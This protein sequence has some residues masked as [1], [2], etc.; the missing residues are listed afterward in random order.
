[1]FSSSDLHTQGNWTYLKNVL[2]QII[3]YIKWMFSSSDFLNEY[4]FFLKKNRTP[5]KS[6]IYYFSYMPFLGLKRAPLHRE[7]RPITIYTEPAVLNDYSSNL[8]LCSMICLHIWMVM[9]EYFFTIRFYLINKQALYSNTERTKYKHKSILREK[10][11]LEKLL[12]E[13]C[14]LNP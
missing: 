1:M 14:N 11:T 8:K 12:S 10:K 7:V 13:R 4:I 3:K 2:N 9:F 6:N 5:I